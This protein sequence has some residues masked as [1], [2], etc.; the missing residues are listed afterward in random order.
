MCLVN[1]GEGL[2]DFG[3]SEKLPETNSK[4]APENGGF[5]LEVWRFLL[6]TIIFRGEMLVLGRREES[7]LRT[8][9]VKINVHCHF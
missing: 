6:E 3:D 5:T 7:T 8:K 2:C 9:F 4:F 1:S